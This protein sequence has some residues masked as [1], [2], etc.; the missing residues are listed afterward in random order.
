MRSTEAWGEPPVKPPVQGLSVQCL[1][2]WTTRSGCRRVWKRVLENP[3]M[4]IL[5][6]KT[7]ALS[8]QPTLT[9]TGGRLT[10]ASTPAQS[11]CR[12]LEPCLRGWDQHPWEVS[13]WAQCPHRPD[14][15]WGS[16]PHSRPHHWGGT[17]RPPRSPLPVDTGLGRDVACIR[18]PEPSSAAHASHEGTG[19]PHTVVSSADQGRQSPELILGLGVAGSKAPRDEDRRSLHTDAQEADREQEP[20]SLSS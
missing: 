17:A 13:C 6:N 16:V 9:N 20:P 15:T 12:C 19:A 14:G 1:P 11:S 2:T 5:N 3:P 8:P 4:L 18:W 10:P 7:K